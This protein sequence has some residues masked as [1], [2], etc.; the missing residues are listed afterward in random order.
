MKM[1]GLRAK[2]TVPAL[3]LL[4]MATLTVA[5]EPQR[6]SAT[7]PGPRPS[8]WW[9]PRHLGMN[10]R[11]KLGDVD[12]LFIGDS[13]TE[14]WSGAGM[15][16]WHKYYSRRNAVNLGIGG[17][18]TSHVLW[19][20]D[21]GN[22][23]GVSPKLAVLM[24]GTNNAGLS[25][26]PAEETAEGIKLIVEKLRKKLPKTKI[27]LLAIFPRGV[28]KQ[29]ELRQLNDKTNALIAPLADHETVFYMDLGSKFVEPDGKVNKDLMPDLLHLSNTGYE[30]WAATIEPTVARLMGEK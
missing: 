16:V 17:D 25:K 4:A 12:L 7:V 28:D 11:I 22:I 3:L 21:N 24:I 15:G 5:K 6:R 10:D 30:I 29:D 27:L 18:E 14:G 20:L 1:S 19:R 9:M 26:L 13:I 2:M 23:D 8:V